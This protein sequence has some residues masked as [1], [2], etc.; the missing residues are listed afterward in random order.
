[1]A[2]GNREVT[3]GGWLEAAGDVLI[4]EGISALKAD[5]LAKRLA[6]I[7]MCGLKC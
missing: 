2:R 5:R 4:E 3:R 7:L 6:V 1:M